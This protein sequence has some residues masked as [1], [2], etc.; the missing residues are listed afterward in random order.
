MATRAAKPVTVTLGAQGEG[1][2]RRVDSGQYASMSEVVRAGLRAL[3][4]EE[5]AV[6]EALRAR[7]AASLADPRASIPHDQVFARLRAHNAQA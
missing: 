4:R 5:Q 2:R 6:D 3:Q 7:I 1:A